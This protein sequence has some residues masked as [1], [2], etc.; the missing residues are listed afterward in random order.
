M[1]QL[2]LQGLHLLL[3]PTLF[4]LVSFSSLKH[5]KKRTLTL[6]IAGYR[7]EKCFG[8]LLEKQTQNFSADAVVVLTV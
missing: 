3:S 8:T 2:L 5:S 4:L 6:G 7:E 1:A